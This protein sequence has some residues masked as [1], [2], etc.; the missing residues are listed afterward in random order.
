MLGKD[1]RLV[2]AQSVITHA[3][4]NGEHLGAHAGERES[5]RR[6]VEPVALKRGA[7]IHVDLR[8]PSIHL[9]FDNVH[10]DAVSGCIIRGHE[11]GPDFGRLQFNSKGDVRW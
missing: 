6:S 3:L 4:R 7:H 5:K 8:S 11:K 2:E 10:I 1:A 9:A